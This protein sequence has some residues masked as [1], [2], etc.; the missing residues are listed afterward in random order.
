M[1]LCILA[2]I[3]AL[4][5]GIPLGI[6]AAF[7]RNKPADIAISVFALLGFSVPVF[8]LA[9]VLTLFFSLHLGWLPV[10]GRIDLLYNLKTVTGFALV[11][12]WLSDSPTV[13]I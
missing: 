6:I 11:D 1:E 12:A 4:T 8:V 9:L 2:F 13:K 7:W 3:F 10:S 5:T